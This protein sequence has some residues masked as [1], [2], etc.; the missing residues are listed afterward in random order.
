MT[1]DRLVDVQGL[2]LADERAKLVRSEVHTVEVGKTVLALDLI[3][4]K[5][6]L[7]ESV[8]VVLVEVGERKF[9]D[10]A[11]ERIVGVLCQR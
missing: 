6:D 5:L 10:S 8:L 1:T 3:D 4:A 11:L 7:S 2:P 9:E